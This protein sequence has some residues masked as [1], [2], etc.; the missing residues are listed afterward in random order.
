MRVFF[1]VI[2][3]ILYLV[4]TIPLWL[5]MFIWDRFNKP[6]CDR[7]AYS[8]VQRAFKFVL[9]ILG[10]KAEVIGLEKIAEVAKKQ[11][12]LYVGN[13]QS[14]VD[15]VLCYSLMP[16]ITGFVSKDTLGKVPLL[17]AWMR[18]TYCLFLNRSNTK[19]AITVIKNAVDTVKSG[20]SIFI[21][22]EGTRSKNGEVAQFKE[23]S[24]KIAAKA[25][26][27]IIPVAITGSRQAFEGGYTW[28]FQSKKVTVKFAEPIFT[29]ELT[30]EEK[31][32]LG[33]MAREKI[34]ELL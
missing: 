24:M 10:V 20:K 18:K 12:C 27:P 5:V 32:H 8:L 16:T 29:A 19:A 21:F 17:A 26:S 34:V 31:K 23:G 15:V 2:F 30:D 4:L 3:L 6:A 14:Y 22:P 11:G 33:E 28:I 25:N 9:W 1:A 7:F 13:H